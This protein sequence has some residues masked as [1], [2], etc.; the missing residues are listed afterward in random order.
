MQHLKQPTCLAIV[1]ATLLSVAAAHAQ[2]GQ[3]AP[4]PFAPGVVTTISPERLYGET[5][6][7]HD[8]VELRTPDL[9]HSPH[10][11]PE[12]RTLYAMAGGTK[13]HRKIWALE[14]NFKPLRMLQVDIPQ[15]TGHMQRKLVWY[16]VYN[17]RNLGEELVPAEKEDGTFEVRTTAEELQFI[18]HLV[19]ES[20]EFGKVYLDRIIPAALGP[21]QRREA[22]HVPLLTSVEMAETPIRVSAGRDSRP[23]WGVAMWEDVDPRIDFLSIYVDG[24]TNAYRAEDDPQVKHQRGDPPGKGRRIKRKTL[25]LNFWRPGDTVD[26]SE[27]EIRFSTPAGREAIYGV[28][29]GVDYTWVYR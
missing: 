11:T 4:G 24:L 14:F 3:L 20:H 19:L 16:L 10:Y 18:P 9:K 1:A 17:V 2:E 23:V 28:K 7:T 5:V 25:Q 26:E 15:P 12:S 8:V 27:E 29:P 21:I 6:S 22:P 13:F